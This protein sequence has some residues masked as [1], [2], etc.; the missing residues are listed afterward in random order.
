MGSYEKSGIPRYKNLKDYTYHNR[1]GF[2]PLV[3]C[4][5]KINRGVITI[6]GKKTRN[7]F[8]LDLYEEENSYPT[9]QSVDLQYCSHHSVLDEIYFIMNFAKDKNLKIKFE[10]KFS[11]SVFKCKKCKDISCS[12]DMDNDYKNKICYHCRPKKGR[13]K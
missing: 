13:L 2:Y 6:F 5:K 4:E 12:N 11:D 9:I 10:I 1:C 8:M 3:N 7:Y